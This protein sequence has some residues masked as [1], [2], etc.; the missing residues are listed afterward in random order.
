MSSELLSV[1]LKVISIDRYALK[2]TH[3][4]MCVCVCI[5]TCINLA[6]NHIFSVTSYSSNLDVEFNEI[7][8]TKKLVQIV[9]DI[10]C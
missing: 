5:C 7:S 4:C 6:Q 3:I 8:K 1:L 2:H 10:N 9:K